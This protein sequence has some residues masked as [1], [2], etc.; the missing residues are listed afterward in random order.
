MKR[1]SGTS[2]FKILFIGGLVVHVV[3][4]LFIAALVAVGLQ[5]IGESTNLVPTDTMTPIAFLGAYLVLGVVLSPAWVGALWLS[6]WPGVW[7]YSQFRPM[8]LGYIPTD[9]EHDT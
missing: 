5:P 3:I 2:I 1:I 7:L 8:N 4:T 9:H 6:I